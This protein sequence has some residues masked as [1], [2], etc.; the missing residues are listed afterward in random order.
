[1]NLTLLPADVNK[2]V[3]ADLGRWRSPLNQAKDDQVRAYLTSKG[4]VADRKS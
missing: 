4:A 3:V 2:G 1:M